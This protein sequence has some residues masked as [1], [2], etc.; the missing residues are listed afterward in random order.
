MTDKPKSRLPFWSGC[1]IGC[2]LLLALTGA[3][4]FVG[5]RLVKEHY[6]RWIVSREIAG[7]DFVAKGFRRV[8]DVTGSNS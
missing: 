6:D 3:A 5:A 2:L 4:I 7:A 1:A 8:S